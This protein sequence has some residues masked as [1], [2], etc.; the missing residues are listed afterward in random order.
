MQKRKSKFPTNIVWGELI[1]AG[2]VSWIIK[3]VLDYTY[4][5]SKARIILF[6]ESDLLRKIGLYYMQ[7]SIETLTVGFDQSDPFFRTPIFLTMIESMLESH[8][9]AH[10]KNNIE[11]ETCG[12]CKL[13]IQNKAFFQKVLP[14]PKLYPPFQILTNFFLKPTL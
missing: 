3:K 9:K 4:E 6:K 8:E 2:I 5:Q 13:I 12:I 10:R 1:L 7:F 14:N 11:I